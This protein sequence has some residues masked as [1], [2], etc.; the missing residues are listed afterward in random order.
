MLRRLRDIRARSFGRGAVG[1]SRALSAWEG[2]T[3]RLWD[4]ASGAELRRL[5]GHTGWVMSVAICRMVAAPCRGRGIIPCGCGT[6]RAGPCCAASRDIPT[7]SGVAVLPD[8]RRALS[9]SG[10][11]TLRL[12]DIESGAELARYVG[13]FDFA[14]LAV[15]PGGGRVLTGNAIGQVVPFGLPSC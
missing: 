13:D 14:A 4:V 6:S 1:W 15:M 5:E 2:E 7:G 3:L 12:W 8:G 9:G 10:D 11:E